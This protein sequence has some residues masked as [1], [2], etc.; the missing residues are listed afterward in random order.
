MAVSGGSGGDREQILVTFG[1]CRGNHGRTSG[2]SEM[3]T[4]TT[5][6]SAKVIWGSRGRTRKH[7]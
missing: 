1:S 2:R 5:M 6:G 4:L 3:G 7:G